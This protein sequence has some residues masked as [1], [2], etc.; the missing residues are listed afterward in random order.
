[1]DLAWRLTTKGYPTYKRHLAIFGLLLLCIAAEELYLLL[2]SDMRSDWLPS[3]V[4]I[5]VG[6]SIGSLP[7]ILGS[8]NPAYGWTLGLNKRRDPSR[9]LVI[10]ADF[11]WEEGLTGLQQATLAMPDADWLFL[12]DVFDIWVGIKGFETLP[13]RNF[14]WWVSER[15]RTGHWIGLWLGNREYFLD[16][17]ADKFD[18]IGEGINGTLQGEPFVFEHGDLINPND[19][20]YRL[21]NVLSRSGFTWILGKIMPSF[22]RKRLTLYLV[23]KLQTTNEEYKDKFPKYEF[24]NAVYESGAP[25]FIT[26]H[27]HT[28]E[29]VEK[30]ISIPWAKEGKFLLWQNG[31]FT[32]VDTKLQ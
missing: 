22:I 27:F 7:F 1:M 32:I 12:G 2:T 5:I 31:E 30:G 15:R 13:Q 8:R 18:F 14:I 26:G 23:E 9:R 11:H 10:A 3:I 17:L 21:W 16:D 28:L 20:H 19:R 24:Q 6:L 29:K 25:F 4:G